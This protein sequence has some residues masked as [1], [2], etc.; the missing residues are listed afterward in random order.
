[1]RRYKQN[2]HGGGIRDPL[3]ISW[4]ARIADAGSLRHQFCHACD[5]APTILEL[6]GLTPPETIA[7]VAQMQLEGISF[8]ASLADPGAPARADAQYFEMFGHRGLWADGWKAVAYHPPGAAFEADIWELYHL[9]RDFSE[10]DDLAIAEPARLAALIEQWWDAARRH[11]VLPLDDRFGPRFAE[12]AKRSHTRRQYIFHAGVGHIPTDAAPDVRGRNYLIEAD[13]VIGAAGAEGVLIAHGDATCGYCLF[14][15]DG[16]L[17]HDINV[18]GAHRILTSD[19]PVPAGA[20]TL[21][22]RMTVKD[23]QRL[24]ALV[25]NGA[26]AGSL[27]Y[28]IGFV[29]FISWSGLDI[30][31]DRGSPVSSYAA[32]FAFTGLLRKVTVTME[33]D[34]D[35]DA[36]G[37]AQAELAR[38]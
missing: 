11:K 36:E 34:Q 13:V 38:Q 25:I 35:L 22:F 24:G 12:N 20:C 4:P 17:V 21:G 37:V 15:R 3:V 14:V 6:L 9:D 27:A 8:A 18:G 1:L 5:V 7:G 2:T 32:P 33:P 26:P 16:R 23:N 29:N 31:L 28:D 19:R 10:T 30:G